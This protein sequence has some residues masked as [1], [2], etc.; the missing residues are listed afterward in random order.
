MI[1]LQAV[2]KIMFENILTLKSTDTRSVYRIIELVQ[3]FLTQ[4]LNEVKLIK[5]F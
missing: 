4:F 5:I 3:M 1:C 2:Y